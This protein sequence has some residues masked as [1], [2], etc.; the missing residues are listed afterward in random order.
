MRNDTFQTLFSSLAECENIRIIASVDHINAPFMWDHTKSMKFNWLWH[1]ITSY[2]PYL[3]ETTFENSILMKSTAIGSN[4]ILYVLK[5][6]NA[7]A[8]GVSILF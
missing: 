1:D 5:S 2:E 8:R 7:N 3:C 4:G 6:L